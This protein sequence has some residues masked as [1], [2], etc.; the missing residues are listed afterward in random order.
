MIVTLTPNPCIDRTVALSTPLVRGAVVRADAELSQPG[1]KG[2]NISRAAVAAGVPTRAVLPVAPDDPYVHELIALGVA[3]VPVVPAGPLRVNLTITEPGGTTTK[4]NSAGAR[5]SAD[6]LERMAIAVVDQDDPAWVVLAGSLPPGA[7]AEWYV[8]VVARLR[9][10]GRR[11]AV[12]TSDAALEALVA[13]AAPGT[14]PDLLKPNTEE[15]ASVTGAD[16]DRLEGDPVAAAAA[17]RLLLDR[18]VGAVLATL[19]GAGAVLVTE[20]GAWYAVPPPTQVVSTVGAGDASLF[21]YL[22]ADLRGQSAPERLASAVAYGSA[23][24]SLPGT[25]V[26]T[27][28]DV[29][30]DQVRVSALDSTSGAVSTE[31]SRP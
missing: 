25:T 10:R 11:V 3:V 7:P 15:L 26:P 31:G 30:T 16:P 12:D 4:V 2:V 1:G 18:G 28:S 8:D 29:R 5:V 19:G 27:P 9:A 13:A 22:L 24:A 20:E 6:D 23:A 14:A 17:A 21:G